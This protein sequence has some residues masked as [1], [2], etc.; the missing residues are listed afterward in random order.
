MVRVE[1]AGPSALAIASA[2]PE[3][4]LIKQMLIGAS[5][6]FCLG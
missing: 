1:K 3:S 2:K 6:N 5:L 4:W